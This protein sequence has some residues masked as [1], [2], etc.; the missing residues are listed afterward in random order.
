MAVSDLETVSIVIP[1]YQGAETIV[2]VVT[3]LLD[4][5]DSSEVTELRLEELVL[6][7]DGAIDTSDEGMVKLSQQDARV[8][9]VWLSRNYGQHA[10]TL[11][12]C[13]S[14]LGDWIVTMD[15]D[16][17]HDPR[18]ISAM[19]QKSRESGA[20]L[21][22]AH[23]L[24]HPHSRWRVMTSVVAKQFVRSLFG[25]EGATDFSSFRLLDGFAT[26][27]LAAYCGHGVYLDV[28]LQWVFDGAATVR[29]EYRQELRPSASGYSLHTLISHFRRMVLTAG[30]RPLR[31][32]SVFGFV[33]AFV[34]LLSAAVLIVGRLAGLIAVPGWTSVMVAT[35]VL[36]GIT[37]L[38]L[39][40]IA[41]YL[42]M[43]LGAVNGRPPYLITGRRPRRPRPM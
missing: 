34:G 27:A 8:K 35:L 25:I 22:Y 29:T 40:V 5:F 23:P 17:L 18:A 31:L 24:R 32:A 19:L 6:V 1:V 38:V 12:G 42:T 20:G 26:R 36:F 14:T 16:G 39:G 21:V 4:V 33:T 13:A 37:L 30:P 28:A 11:A 43:V 10:A 41:E 3:E 15:E 7:H 2:T 9:P